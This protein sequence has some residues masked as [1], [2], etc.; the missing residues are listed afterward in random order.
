MS[1]KAIYFYTSVIMIAIVFC[2]VHKMVD[3]KH[4]R[5]AKA[6]GRDEEW[7]GGSASVTPFL[8]PPDFFGALAAISCAVVA[9]MIYLAIF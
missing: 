8:S 7:Y 4:Q 6:A 1:S 3:N 9:M 2:V 5:A